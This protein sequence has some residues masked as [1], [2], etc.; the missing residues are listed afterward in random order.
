MKKKKVRARRPATPNQKKI[1]YAIV[2]LGWISQSSA[3]PAFKHAARNSKLVALVSSDSE[4]LKELGAKYKVPHLYLADQYDECLKNPEVDAI[5]IALPNTMH[6]EYTIRAAQYG[7]HVLCEKP[8]GVN[9]SECEQMI[10]A[11]EENGVK[12]MTAYRLHFDRATLRAIE[13]VKNGKLGVPRLFS[14]IFSYSISD[15]SNSRLKFELGGGPLFDIGIYCINA[16][17]YLFQSEPISVAAYYGTGDDPRFVEV[18]EAVTGILKFP[19]GMLAQFTCSFGAAAE[20]VVEILGTKGKLRMEKAF[21]ISDRQKHILTLNESE[22]ITE[23][24]KKDQFAPEFI[25]FSDCI[26][27][28]KNPEPSG[29]EGLI[30]VY[31]IQSMYESIHAGRSIRLENIRAKEK[32][33]LKLE[34]SKPPVQTPRV[35]HAVDP[36][37]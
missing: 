25:Y 27:T 15:P 36:A 28:G 32:P 6:A 1:G 31:V 33:S 9:R 20:S 11:C 24:A 8:L 21:E 34:Y 4:K 23:F 18:E 12:L 26:L 37:A 16:A 13:L 14:S 22:K 30:D 29:Y 35:V 5:Y 7:K 2:G 19:E 3:L 10:L 17:R